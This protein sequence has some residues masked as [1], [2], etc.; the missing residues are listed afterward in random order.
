MNLK[1]NQYVE[2]VKNLVLNHFKNY[3]VKIY[4]FGSRARNSA[5]MASDVDVA[6]L[7]LETI[8]RFVFSEIREKLEE[9]NVPYEVDIVNLD[10]AEDELK[11]QIL[12]EGILWRG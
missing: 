8:E 4:F 1:N 2:Q 12:R 9:S 3:K 11:E 6:I 5:S 7:P 10:D